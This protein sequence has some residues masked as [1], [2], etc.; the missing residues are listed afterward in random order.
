MGRAN[1]ESFILDIMTRNYVDHVAFAS[2]G[3]GKMIIAI[4]KANEIVYNHR[5]LSTIMI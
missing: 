4:Y 1:F 2:S 5:L 3:S